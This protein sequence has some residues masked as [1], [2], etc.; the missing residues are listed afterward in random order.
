MAQEHILSL[1]VSLISMTSLV[2]QQANSGHR[3]ICLVTKPLNGINN[4]R[5]Q[6]SC[7]GLL[8]HI[9][10]FQPRTRIDRMAMGLFSKRRWTNR[11]AQKSSHYGMLPCRSSIIFKGAF[12]THN[13]L[14]L[15]P[16]LPSSPST[17]EVHGM[18]FSSYLPES[19]PGQSGMATFGLTWILDWPP[20]CIFF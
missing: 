12:H 15:G 5:R 14:P 2:L 1:Y 19:H 11:L 6:D 10:N 16:I 8:L 18:A 17:K 7:Q 3:N 9:T 13:S 20:I 4:C